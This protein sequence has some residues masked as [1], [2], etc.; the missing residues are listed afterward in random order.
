MIPRLKPGGGRC[1]D[2]TNIAEGIDDCLFTC[3]SFHSVRTQAYVC[4][5]HGL[6]LT[7]NVACYIADRGKK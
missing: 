7:P 4:N 3:E 1:R 5:A 6:W 2:S